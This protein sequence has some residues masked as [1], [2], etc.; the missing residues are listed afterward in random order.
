MFISP[1]FA[2]GAS[3]DGGANMLIQFAPFILIFVIFYFLI[4][5]P[6][7]KKQKDHRNMLAAIR[8]GDNIITAGGLMGKVSKVV[9][10]NEVEV[11]IAKD[12]RVRVMRNFI[13]DVRSKGEPAKDN[14]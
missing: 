7:Q 5:R 10:D 12:I 11:E 13:Q 8:R 1:A 6:Q 3:A 14:S 2:Q 9:D 4:I